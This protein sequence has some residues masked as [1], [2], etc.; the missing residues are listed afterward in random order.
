M[1]KDNNIHEGHRARMLDR[2]NKDPNGFAEHELLEILLYSFIPR[3][4]TNFIAHDLINVFGSLEGVFSASPK[5]LASIEG[6]GEKTSCNIAL[7]GSIINNIINK[8]KKTKR[9]NY[10]NP[11]EIVR[12]KKDW[13]FNARDE[14]FLIILLDNR[15]NE[16]VTLNFTDKQKDKVT[17]DVK[18]MMNAISLHKPDSIVMVHN[19]PSR[20]VNPSTQDDLSTQKANLVCN[21][22]GVKLQDHI[23]THGETFFSYHSSGRMDYI[24]D[25]TDI[26]KLIGL[27]KE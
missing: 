23:I 9:I 1:G 27:I 3:V 5:E 15:R 25:T 6:V 16:I 11:F 26:E 22:T 2:F 8:R 13:F 20:D 18:L 24:R 10:L 14:M 12:E 7:L 21:L 4:N 17:V 19:H